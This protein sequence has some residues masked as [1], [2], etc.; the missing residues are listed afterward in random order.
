[1]QVAETRFSN[2]HRMLI[3]FKNDME[4][5]ATK[6]LPIIAPLHELLLSTNI[7]IPEAVERRLVEIVD[8]WSNNQPG[9]GIKPLPAVLLPVNER[10]Q[11][12]QTIRK[13]DAPKDAASKNCGQANDWKND[14]RAIADELHAKDV[15]AGAYSSTDDISHR[16][17]KLADDRGIKGPRG[18]LTAGN[19]KREALQGGRWIRKN[20]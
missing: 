18:K 7:Y 14:V 6:H 8:E 4:S 12:Q 13:N 10:A 9:F 11:N 1:M 16:A 3:E 19:I 17:A 15:R 20:N 5:H 2:N